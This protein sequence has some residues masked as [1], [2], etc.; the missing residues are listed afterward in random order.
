MLPEPSI[1][2]DPDIELPGIEDEEEEF[3]P[4][5]EPAK[6]TT[7]EYKVGL[8]EDFSGKNKDT[9]RWL[10]AMKCYFAMNSHIYLDKKVAAMVFLNKMS[11]GRG[12]LFTEGWYN[13]L[14]KDEVPEE[15]KTFKKS[16]TALKKPSFLKTSMTEPANP[17]IP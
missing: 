13:K 4:A 1:I 7:P 2:P 6:M 14:A 15:E 8:P 16:V 17:S 11:K 12:A 9:T 3:L 10:M 5:E